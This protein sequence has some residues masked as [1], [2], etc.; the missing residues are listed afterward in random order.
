MEE[1]TISDLQN[2]N[3]L[4]NKINGHWFKEY[5]VDNVCIPNFMELMTVSTIIENLDEY[6][7]AAKTY[8]TEA[9]EIYAL[10]DNLMS[11]AEDKNQIEKY[12]GNILEEAFSIYYNGVRSF[13]FSFELIKEKTNFVLDNKS[14]INRIMHD[15][16]SAYVN[17]N[18]Y[19]ITTPTLD[20]IV[21]YLASLS[22]LKSEHEMLSEY[23]DYWASMYDLLKQCV[24]QCTKVRL[25]KT[26][27]N[28]V[29]KRFTMILK[30]LYKYSN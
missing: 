18:D 19:I 29:S 27:K 30:E 28:C 13:D 10:F 14:D 23:H 7:A 2:A 1:L 4:Y 3:C 17:M 12:Y 21:E 11:I 6:H 22:N 8:E 9:E 15:M 16:Y 24:V 5:K 26:V 25:P 20:T